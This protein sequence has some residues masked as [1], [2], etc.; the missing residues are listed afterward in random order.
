MKME[1]VL[2]HQSSDISPDTFVD[3]TEENADPVVWIAN[4]DTDNVK[5]VYYMLR[6]DEGNVRT[7]W[8]DKDATRSEVASA[9]ARSFTAEMFGEADNNYVDTWVIMEIEGNDAGFYVRVH[10]VDAS[11]LRGGYYD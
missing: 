7:L 10:R 8:I 11:G 5:L 2:K 9:V 4:C 1:I 3:V 6:K